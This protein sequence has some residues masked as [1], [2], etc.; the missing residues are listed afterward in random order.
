MPSVFLLVHHVRSLITALENVRS[1]MAL[2]N[3]A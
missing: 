1:L 3:D 2:E